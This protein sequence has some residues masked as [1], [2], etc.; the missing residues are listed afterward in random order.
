[1]HRFNITFFIPDLTSKLIKFTA[2]SSVKQITTKTTNA[3]LIAKL[4]K[5]IKVDLVVFFYHRFMF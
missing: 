2:K 1:M 5:F 3:L 4:L